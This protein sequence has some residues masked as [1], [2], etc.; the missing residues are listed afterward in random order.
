MLITDIIKNKKI[1]QEQAAE[2]IG[3]DQ[4]KVSKI[5]RGLLAEFTVERLMRYVLR[6]G[7]DLEIWP[8]PHKPKNTTA[9]IHV[10]YP[11][12]RKRRQSQTV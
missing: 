9:G 2:L 6:L 12:T 8:V 7:F 5:T 1:T 11:K 4:P 3:I 10:H